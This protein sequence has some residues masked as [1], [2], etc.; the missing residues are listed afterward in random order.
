MSSYLVIGMG[1]FGSAMATELYR[2]GHEVFVIDEHEESIAKVVDYVTHAIVGNAND[3][4]V[5]KSISVSH[6][7]CIVVAI[8]GGIEESVLI[9]LMVKE[10]GAK[11]IIAKAQNEQHAKVLDRVGAD[12]V[13]RPEHDMGK[14]LAHS[15]AH[16]NIIDLIELSED[17]RIA[18]ISPLKAWLGKTLGETNLRRKY[19]LTVLAIRSEGEKEVK[20]SPDADMHIKSGDVLV[21]I[22]AI[23]DLDAVGEMA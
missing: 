22:G 9:T 3:E 20:I 13:I 8:A 10:M 1:R 21:V 18:E 7:D 6:F 14:R 17:H 23:R 19:G 2:L 11:R 4:S 16:R 5:L 12:K 15:L